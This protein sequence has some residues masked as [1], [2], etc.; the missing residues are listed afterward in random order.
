MGSRCIP[1]HINVVNHPGQ[2]SL[3]ISSWVGEMRTGDQSC[4]L[5]G[6]VLASRTPDE[7]LGLDLFLERKVLDT[8]MWILM[9]CSCGYC[10]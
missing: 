4:C 10:R 6:L 3:A 1:H 9:K 2:L 5:R 7:G 8:K